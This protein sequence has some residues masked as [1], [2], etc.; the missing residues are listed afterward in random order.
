ML[1]GFL[2]DPLVYLLLSFVYAILVAI[3]LPIPIE[4]AFIWPFVSHQFGLF[5]A[6]LI[7]IA[8]GKALG[9]MLVLLL[10]IK[11]EKS[12]FY[13]SKKVR[14]FG[15]LVRHLTKFVE[16][17]GNI[18]LYIILSIPLMTDTI[19]IYIYSIFHPQGKAPKKSLFA[20]TN[21]AAG[22]TRALIIAAIISL[23]GITLV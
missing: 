5:I 20:L 17:T 7:V 3:I 16:R 15:T 12:V 4:I 22:V 11:V 18:G 6:V 1:E 8:L 9:A 2:A 14:W 21:F 13:W 10:G 23:F 19:P